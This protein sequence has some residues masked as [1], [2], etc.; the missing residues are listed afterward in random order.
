MAGLLRGWGCE[1]LFAGYRLRARQQV[2]DLKCRTR[3]L[4]LAAE[5]VHGVIDEPDDFFVAR[6]V[7]TA[8]LVASP[9]G[10]RIRRRLVN[11]NVWK[12]GSGFA[13]M[14]ATDAEV[15]VCR[16]FPGPIVH[17]F[18]GGADLRRCRG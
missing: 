2:S 7:I 13:N 12:A 15:P 17:D 10:W 6:A 3:W 16:G 18:G 8:S 4:T 14:A 11:T 5:N 9:T 1:H